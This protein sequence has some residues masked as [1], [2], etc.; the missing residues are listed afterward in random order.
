M[1]KWV[2]PGVYVNEVDVISMCVPSVLGEEGSSLM[3]HLFGQEPD[4][5]LQETRCS[6]NLA[7]GQSIYAFLCNAIIVLGD[8]IYMPFEATFDLKHPDCFQKIREW[9]DDVTPRS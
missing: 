6:F 8:G 5:L 3:E 7:N 9:L 2:T 4:F 1:V